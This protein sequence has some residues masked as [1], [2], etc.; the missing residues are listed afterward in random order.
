M[1]D[2]PG[3]QGT[4]GGPSRRWGVS[5]E[6]EA[7]GNQVLFGQRS[8]QETK[9]LQHSGI[10]DVR[11]SEAG[12]GGTNVDPTEK[13]LFWQQIRGDQG[14]PGWGR[15]GSELERGGGRWATE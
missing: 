8:R 12:V 13:D 5:Y 9:G 11:D 4:M 10:Q 2:Q 7:W 15:T 3:T 1:H 6:T 14:E